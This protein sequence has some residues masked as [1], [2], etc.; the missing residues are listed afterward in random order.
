MG[1]S[2][3]KK[4]E[5][6]NAFSAADCVCRVLAVRGRAGC[7]LDMVTLSKEDADTIADALQES[8]CTAL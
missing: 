3:P 2:H 5:A 7:V 6:P 4:P 1:Q 8:T